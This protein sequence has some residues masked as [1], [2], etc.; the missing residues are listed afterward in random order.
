MLEQMVQINPLVWISLTLSFL[1]VIAIQVF[2]HRKSVR[3]LEE[4]LIEN[5]RAKDT[6]A[7]KLGNA[8]RSLVTAT[9]TVGD[10]DKQIAELRE[11]AANG[12]APGYRVRRRQNRSGQF[13]FDI[14]DANGNSKMQSV[15]RRF[16]SRRAVDASASECFPNARITPK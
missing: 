6:L 9:E 13:F 16:A 11:S 4:S 10:R 3:S 8:R 7:E 14:A 15:Y 1:V 5:L 2:A 12:L